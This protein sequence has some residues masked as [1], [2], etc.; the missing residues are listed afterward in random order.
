[1]LGLLLLLAGL[2]TL[3]FGLASFFGMKRMSVAPF[4]GTGEIASGQGDAPLPADTPVATE[5]RI[6]ADNAIRAP[7]SGQTCLYYEVTLDREWERPVLTGSGTKKETGTTRVTTS[8]G[9]AIFQLDDG[10]GPVNIDARDEVQ[11]DL[12]KSHEERFPIGQ[13]VPGE[14]QFG[15]MRVQTPLDLGSDRTTAFIA[16]ERILLSQGVLYACGRLINGAI[17]KPPWGPLVLSQNG[18]LA[19]LA[20]ARRRAMTLLF[21]GAAFTAGSIPAFLFAR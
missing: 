10:S 3:G 18:R 1:M 9:G 14:I 16:T 21:V 13:T 17:G 8:R 2:V 5:G 7:C 11:A 15:Q 20:A 19:L 12:A 6:L 4:W